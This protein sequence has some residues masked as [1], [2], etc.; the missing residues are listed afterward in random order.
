MADTEQVDREKLQKK[1]EKKYRKEV[2]HMAESN[3]IWLNAFNC[4][5]P[6]DQFKL[7]LADSILRMLKQDENTILTKISRPGFAFEGVGQRELVLRINKS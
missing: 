1:S 7:D 6:T 3:H 4:I 2:L 5:R